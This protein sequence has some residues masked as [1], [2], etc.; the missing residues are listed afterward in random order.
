MCRPKR[1]YVCL[2]CN[3][4]RAR[5]DK[6]YMKFRDM[7]E[8]ENKNIV[9]CKNCRVDHITN[10]TLSA[11]EGEFHAWCFDEGVFVNLV[12]NQLLFILLALYLE[13][14]QRL[15]SCYASH[16]SSRSMSYAANNLQEID[17]L[18]LN[19][20]VAGRWRYVWEQGNGFGWKL[21]SWQTK[22]LAH[23]SQAPA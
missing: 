5:T 10:A 20:N 21:V 2:D 17:L 15:T 3:R 6:P 12:S 22:S 9:I 7:P 1:E 23:C 13:F 11:A 19:L 8:C 4:S 18:M 16:R 14:C